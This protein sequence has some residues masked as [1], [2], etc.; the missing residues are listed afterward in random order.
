MI[1]TD[2]QYTPYQVFVIFVKTFNLIMF[3]GL[4]SFKLLRKRKKWG[5]G[6]MGGGLGKGKEEGAKERGK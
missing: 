2:K 5:V 1:F 3:S 4:K 6:D